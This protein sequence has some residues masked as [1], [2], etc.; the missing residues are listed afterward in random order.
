M[1]KES[2]LELAKLDIKQLVDEMTLTKIPETKEKVFSYLMFLTELDRLPQINTLAPLPVKPIEPVEPATKND[3]QDIEKPI[4]KEVPEVVEPVKVPY[5]FE[6]KLKGGWLPN[7]QAFVPERM[8]RELEL[9]H[10]DLVYASKLTQ[11]SQTEGP[12]RYSFELAERRNESEPKDRVQINYAIVDWDVDIKRFV[13]SSTI[14]EGMIRDS[15]GTPMTLLIS[16]QEA[17]DLKIKEGDIV[18]VAYHTGQSS[19]IRLIWRYSMDNPAEF[20]WVTANKKKH[21]KS[22]TT[23]QREYP[24]TLSEMTILMIGFEPGKKD[25]EEE[26]IRR[27]GTMIWASGREGHDRIFTMVNKSDCVIN[28]LAHMGHSGS[29]SAVDIAKTLDIPH[30]RVHNF[31]RTSFIQEIYR[32][33]GITS[34]E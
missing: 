21:Y 18:D 33:L 7:I 6:R 15:D 20:Q 29:I 10:G 25:M 34:A 23:T 30:G 3:S 4:E 26:I 28:M 22:T 31:G 24:Q 9:S 16:D 1:N 2:I 19:V 27:G 13:V 14:S 8:V 5:R 11:K 32:C 12:T 17:N